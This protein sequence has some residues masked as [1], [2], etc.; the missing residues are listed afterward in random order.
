MLIVCVMEPCGDQVSIVPPGLPSAKSNLAL[1]RSRL[2]TDWWVK[3]NVQGERICYKT[4]SKSKEFYTANDYILEGF[5]L[6]DIVDEGH[7][8]LVVLD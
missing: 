6:G 3:K 8:A 2:E 7:S 1:Q 5:R 4:N